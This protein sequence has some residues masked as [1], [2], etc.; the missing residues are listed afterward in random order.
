[1]FEG[2]VGWIKHLVLVV[3]FTTF[4]GSL[5]PRNQYLKYANMVLGLIVVMA[6]ADP[7]II[8]M[9]DGIALNDIEKVIGSDFAR[10]DAQDVTQSHVSTYDSLFFR[11]YKKRIDAAIFEQLRDFAELEVVEVDSVIVED[12]TSGKLGTIDSV[13][14]ILRANFNKSAIV[15]SAI[16]PIDKISVGKRIHGDQYT[17]SE[18]FDYVNRIITH[19]GANWGIVE[20]QISIYWEGEGKGDEGS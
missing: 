4:V 20:D 19:M 6:I 5:L 16:V 9:K 18:K 11:H 15:P 12:V 1:M 10:M 3:I 2:I 8:L 14:V 7:L 17:E 13:N